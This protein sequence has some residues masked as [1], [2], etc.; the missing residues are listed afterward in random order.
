MYIRNSLAMVIYRALVAILS[1]LGVWMCFDKFGLEAW[2]VF[3]T[4]VL[5]VTAIYFGIMSIAGLWARKERR[6]LTGSPVIEGALIISFLV[7][8]ATTFVFMAHG[9]EHPVLNGGAAA[10]SYVTLPVLI[11]ADWLIFL[12]KGRWQGIYPFYW[13]AFPA[14]YIALILFTAEIWTNTYLRYPLEFLDFRTFDIVRMIW[15]LIFYAVCILIAGYI[16]YIIDALISGKVGKYIV[17][18][19]IKLVEVVN[20]KEQEQVGIPEQTKVVKVKKVAKEKRRQEASP[21]TKKSE[22]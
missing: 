10:L 11:I 1:A 16:I 15:A 22:E 21:S 18:P 17:L 6:Q 19:K 5:L 7:A 20:N 8:S 14:I 2:R 12:P 13:L 4:Y 9:W 3:L